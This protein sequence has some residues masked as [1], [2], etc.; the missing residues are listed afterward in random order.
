VH[1]PRLLNEEEDADEGMSPCLTYPAQLARNMVKTIKKPL[2][3]FLLPIKSPFYFKFGLEKK[4]SK[5][6]IFAIE[7]VPTANYA[8][9]IHPPD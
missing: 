6:S 1:C 9:F 5:Y 2:Q 8:I 7:N 3:L 4:L